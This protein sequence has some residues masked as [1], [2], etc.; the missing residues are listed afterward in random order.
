MSLCRYDSIFGQVDAV[1]GDTVVVGVDVLT[2]LSSVPLCQGVPSAGSSQR[3]SPNQPATFHASIMAMP[4][5]SMTGL[6]L[7]EPESRK[8]VFIRMPK[9]AATP[10]SA[11]TM[12]PT[13]I[14]VSPMAIRGPN[15]VCEL[16]S[17]RPCITLL[18]Q[19]YEIEGRAGGSGT[20]TPL[21]V[22]A[23]RLPGVEPLRVLHLVQSRCL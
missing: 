13:P 16:L 12:S 20:A 7:T 14:S 4:S 10:T 11:P 23:Y 2:P 1:G 19:S 17:S 5:R 22:G 15:Q 8:L 6:V 21:P 9:K 3:S 18:H